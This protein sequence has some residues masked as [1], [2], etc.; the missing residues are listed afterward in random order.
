MCVLMY[1]S[2]VLRTAEPYVYMN[3]YLAIFLL[4]IL[5]CKAGA[6][7]PTWAFHI[8]STTADN[9]KAIKVAPN[10][11]VCVTGKFTG[12][13]DLDPGPGV[14]NITSHGADDIFLACYTSSG[15]FLWGFGVGGGSYDGAW[16]MTIDNSNNVIICGYIQSAGIDF[17]PGAGTAILPYVG[18]TGL[19]YWG[20]CFIAKYSSTGAYQWAYDIGGTTVYDHGCSLG[21]DDRGNVYL[22]GEADDIF[23]IPGGPTFSSAVDGQAFL[24]KYTAAGAFVWAHNYGLPG[25]TSSDVIP[26]DLRVSSGFIYVD[27]IFQGTSNFDPWSTPAILTSVGYYDAYIAKYDTNGN[28][29]YVKQVEGTGT[30]EEALGMS[31]DA[32]D[33]VYITG[34]TNSPAMIFDP[35]SP[36]TSTVA[37]P[38]GG[39]NKD[40]FIA[41]YNSAGLYQWGTVLGG[42]GD[43][44]G[45]GIDVA[46]GYVYCTGSF[47]N[48]V[49]MD[50]SASVAD[51]TS[52]GGFD[53]YAT[54]YDLNGN[55]ICGFRVGAAS[56]DIGYGVSHDASGNVYFTGQF[57]GAA[58]DFDPTVGTLAL[59]SNGST[60]VF[61][62]KYVFT[63]GIVDAPNC[64]SLALADTAH[65]CVGDT[66][67]LAATLSGS[68]SVFSILWSPATGLS[69]TT[70]LN[71]TLIV[72]PASSYYTITVRSINPYNL[73]VN[74]DFSAG[75]TGFTSSYTY[76]SGPSSVLL[77]GHYSVYDNPFSVHTGFTSFG[78]H[79]TGTGEMMIINGSPTPTDVWCQTI[80]VDPYTDYDFSAW[81]ANCS[82][83]TVGPD[84][85]TLQFKINGVL[86]GTPTV[87]SSAPG[88]WTN[89]FS[90]WNSGAAT[91]ASIC[92]YDLNTT[93]SGNDF[94]LDD[95][96]FKKICLAVDSI[97]IDVAVRDTTNTNLDTTLCTSLSP[98]TLTATSGYT[99]YLWSTGATTTSISAPITGAYWVYNNNRCST[100]IDSFHVNYIPLPV[101]SLGNDTAF[102][103]GNT[104][105]LTS[106]QPAGSSYLWSTGST[107]DSIFVTTSGTYWLEVNNVYCTAA[108]TIHVTI[109]PPPGVDLGP[110]ISNCLAAPVTLGSSIAYTSPSYL[111]NT[112]STAANITVPTSGTY[113][114]QVTVGGCASAD[115]IN[116]TIVYDTFTLYNN[117]TAIC[118]GRS[119]QALV[120]ADPAVSFSWLPTAGIPTPN[121]SSPLITPDTSDMYYVHIF[122]P[123]CPDLI[124]SFYIDVQPTPDVFMGGNRK[125]C[126][127]D[128]LLLHAS[129][130]PRWYTHYAY[131]WTPATFLDD[132]T[133]ADVVFRAGDSSK[134]ILTVTTP[135]GCTGSDSA[136]VFV[137]PGNF[138]LLDT[139]V[140][141]CPHDSV[142]LIA[143]GGVSYI[144]HP[145]LYLSDS[146]IGSPWVH[147]ITSQGYTVIATSQYGC[148]DTVTANV[149]VHPGAVL[150]L[151][152][153]VTIYP[154][155]SYHIVPQTN[156]VS[157]AWFPPA[158]LDN[159]YIA[160]PVAMPEIN[161]KY[162][163]RGRTEWGC[164]A[165]DSISIYFDPSA[166]LA[167]PNAFT[168]GSGANGK[169][170]IIKRGE[171][172]LNYFRI[173]NRWG[174]LVFETSNI[175]EGWD[176]TYNGKPQPFGVFV[177]QVEA[178][179]KQGNVFRKHGNV[180]L[181]R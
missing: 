81:I 125:V 138:A 53:I 9:G 89:F 171:A 76:A 33:N 137:Y 166:V 154:G 22:G 118:R 180:T 131:S 165:M 41:K 18:G 179:T 88:V 173:F 72:G 94:V 153:S 42:P 111:W 77:E 20:D 145:G 73:V 162:I 4:S 117:D 3:K 25:T 66:I 24:V 115:T 6:Q 108:D 168:P 143:K 181:I 13:M 140:D 99:T 46:G 146:T 113:W 23:T 102:C 17:D 110:D 74:G 2:D 63:C 87:I 98:I 107:A 67:A 69:T 8:G 95:I 176:G 80:T 71:P 7:T 123:G 26:W 39:G 100:L 160:D 91:T 142:Q 120:T 105:T 134:I 62:G 50:P 103:I 124:D 130:T 151:G 79:T 1:L 158:G 85:P 97:Y 149:V 28:F 40:I 101:V 16:N 27:G 136:F 174:N 31:L 21:T 135:A 86:I 48:T 32:S 36:G 37:A 170:F 47:Q 51:L 96:S 14:Y 82:S 56:D 172:D 126:E 128:T 147:A 139:S 159:A 57:G 55:Y 90:I 61:V 60:D 92:I 83:V 133:L 169:L 75:N 70:A 148:L 122:Y 157:F 10:G 121:V 78:D 114:L 177:Y 106:A 127:F 15:A 64:D 150:F 163:V 109:S 152:D 167:L 104:L 178:T 30:A 58:V 29:V 19:A 54:K 11:N 34:Y 161:T 65:A 141:I 35:T 68:D 112:G 5:C 144:W 164:L 93:A 49:D 52:A 43:Q 84:V 119:V 45:W 156:C 175:N 132:T 44:N 129:V 155:E 38:G 116:V 12:T 59:S